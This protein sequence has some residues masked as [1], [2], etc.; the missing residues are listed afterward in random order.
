M[1]PLAAKGGHGRLAVADDELRGRRRRAWH[2]LDR[3]G[4]VLPGVRVRCRL[5]GGRGRGAVGPLLLF[6][7]GLH[8]LV[9]FWGGGSPGK[10]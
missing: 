10:T 1:Q 5:R 4:P 3:L 6:E 2:P 9:F 8:F 7:E